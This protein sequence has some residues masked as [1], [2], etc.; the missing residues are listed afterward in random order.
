MS[1]Q[2]NSIR[3]RWLEMSIDS[4]AESLQR[5][6]AHLA[7][8]LNEQIRDPHD[9]RYGGWPD[10]DCLASPQ[11]SWG[12]SA[13]Y[14]LALV[15]KAWRT[16]G[17][18]YHQSPEAATYIDLAATYL[19]RLIHPGCDFPN[20][21]WA[22]QIGIPHSLG[23]T[24]A[25]AGDAMQP[26]S[27]LGLLAS[28]RH[29]VEAI[30]PFHPAA[31]RMSTA[32]SFLGYGLAAEDPDYLARA[33]DWAVQAS[34]LVDGAALDPQGFRRDATYFY[35]GATVNLGYGRE[36]YLNLAQVMHILEGSPWAIPPETAE[37]AVRFLL[38]FMRWTIA[39]DA[40]DPFIVGR[41]I[42]MS[43][44]AMNANRVLEGSLLL[45]GLKIPR[46]QDVGAC[47]ARLLA[48][49]VKP[50]S[51][52]AERLAR[53]LPDAAPHPQGVRYFADAEYL[54]ARRPTWH[55]TIKMASWRT[56]A[57]LGINRT[58]LKGWH[59]SDG[60]LVL[61]TDGS[62]YRGG[63]IPS[64]DW[65]RLTGI[66][67]ADAF[68]IPAETMG[69]SWFVTGTDNHQLGCCGIDF[70]IR[71]LDRNELLARKSWFILDDAI[72]AMGS[73]IHCD[74]DHEVETIIRHVAVPEEA[75]L[76]EFRAECRFL[77]GHDCAYIL[78]EAP[79]VTVT[80]AWRTGRFTDLR[81]DPPNA[82][83]APDAGECRRR[84]W[85]AIIPH[86][87][88]PRDAGYVMIYLPGKSVAEA[89]AWW[90]AKPI[91]IQQRDALA[92]I[93]H[94]HRRQLAMTVRQWSG[95]TIEPIP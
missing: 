18:R 33:R 76:P 28:Y 53:S 31:N 78:P 57:Y 29:L 91:A 56:K 86:G 65:E 4:R 35:H 41:G 71:N 6:D 9:A 2:W 79:R 85:T 84:F 36:H 94:D 46:R 12:G 26:A 40:F 27:R 24:L 72:V 13:V 49:G 34:A 16:P 17:S 14:R 70:V 37:N 51:N 8:L 45:A 1:T 73:G 59:L 42:S 93:I 3:Q 61:R 88:Q 11:L 5:Q 75:E 95:A 69:H 92:H 80:C 68:K 63:V 47:A 25:W 54:A 90:A 74:G 30:W 43:E 10:V 62:E 83:M 82:A 55:A 38:D 19:G 89:E 58:N 20:N 60:H 21:W 50:M 67:R 44:E 52:F 77:A 23:E 7:R 15:A 22:W 81:Q 32:L 48:D 66:T 39:G 64:M 87:R